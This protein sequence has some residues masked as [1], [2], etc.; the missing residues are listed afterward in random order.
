MKLL[1]FNGRSNIVIKSGEEIYSDTIVYPLK[2]LSE[3]A[4]SIYFGEVPKKLSGH[5]YSLTHSY[6]EL[7][8]KVKEKKFSSKNK[9]DHWY[10]IS[11]MEISSEF[12]KKTIV[13]FG[14]SITDGVIFRNGT[15]DN[16]PD[17]LF[18]E[19]IQNKE[20]SNLSMANE[21]INADRLTDQGIIR[22]DRDVLNV[23]GVAYVIV[24]YGVNDLNVIEAN[25]NEIISGYKEI[26]KK[27]HERNLLIYGGT[28]IPFANYS[29]KYIWN[30]KKEKVRQEANKWIRTTKP[31]DGGF[32]AFIDF[33]KLLKDP[34]NETIMYNK[35]D[36]QDGI[37]PSFE[38]YKKM[39]E[40]IMAL[41]LFS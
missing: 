36:S 2:E 25:S 4:I 20:T 8:N 11:A 30:K 18:Y 32:D 33:D 12:P 14:D 15:R 39:V 35:Y 29:Q 13:C 23:K 19:L 41:S 16:Y 22:Y 17:I 27:A 7:G 10:F 3:V 40:G 26:I 1:T 6:I 21:G 34:K 38:G 24:L 31:K 28:I 5:A 37:H 9:V